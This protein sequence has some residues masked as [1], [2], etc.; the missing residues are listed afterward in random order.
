[1]RPGLQLVAHDVAQR[2][3][4]VVGDRVVDER[5]LAAADDEPGRVQHM[6]VFRDVGLTKIRF[7]HELG[8]GLLTVAKRV[9]QAETRWLTQRPEAL[10]DKDN[11]LRESS[12]GCAWFSWS[13]H[14]NWCLD[15]NADLGA[16]FERVVRRTAAHHALQHFGVRRRQR[17][18]STTRTTN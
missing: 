5:S 11:E 9:Q 13:G 10:G 3:D 15:V 12:R 7:V 18:R 8:D 1:L 17:L 4:A 2:V 6:Q 16:V 14:G